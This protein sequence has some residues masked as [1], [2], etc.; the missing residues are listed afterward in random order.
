MPRKR[1]VHTTSE[2]R[3]FESDSSEKMI[4]TDLKKKGGRP[5][6]A[7]TSDQ[8]G[9]AKALTMVGLSRARI[10]EAIG[11]DPD[12]LAKHFSAELRDGTTHLLAK[13]GVEAFKGMEA[14]K[15]ETRLAAAHYILDR[16]GKEFGWTTKMEVAP[17]RELYAGLD[18]SLLNSEDFSQLQQLLK[19]AGA[20]IELSDIPQIATPWL[21]PK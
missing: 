12:T 7:P 19:K 10:A 11:I 3:I 18:F 8:R 20:P 1:R 2:N 4:P 6:F 16:K 17:R 14:I 9:L 21:R 15:P 5:A 13:A